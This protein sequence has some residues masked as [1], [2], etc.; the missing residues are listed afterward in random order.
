M[1]R[2]IISLSIMFLYHIKGCWSKS[3]YFQR[4]TCNWG[5]TD[6]I[7]HPL[8]DLVWYSQPLTSIF[9][10]VNSGIKKSRI[11]SNLHPKLSMLRTDYKEIVKLATPFYKH[12]WL[13]M[14]NK[15]WCCHVLWCQ[16]CQSL[17][18]NQWCSWEDGWNIQTFKSSFV[19]FLTS[20]ISNEHNDECFCRNDMAHVKAW[21]WKIIQY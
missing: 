10:L 21:L 14:W 8:C 13:H 11:E 16:K 19:T 20:Y 2:L 17:I 5:Y 6:L 15:L 18:H 4:I 3:A 7:P 12:P 1:N 9:C